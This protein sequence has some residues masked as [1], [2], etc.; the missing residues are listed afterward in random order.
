[1]FTSIGYLNEENDFNIFKDLLY[2][3]NRGCIFLIQTENRDWRIMNTPNSSIQD[4]DQVLV[5]E[6]WQLD[7]Y[8]SIAKSQSKYFQR[9]P[10]GCYRLK[11]ELESNIRL[12]SLHELRNIL[13]ESGWNFLTAYGDL[14]TLADITFA[15]PQLITVCQKS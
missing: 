4:L 6:I 12:Y 3:A 15:S 10:K 11:L 9:D 14:L 7:Q 13:Q 8:T 5:N 1:M 2:L